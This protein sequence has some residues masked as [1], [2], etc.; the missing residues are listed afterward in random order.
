MTTFLESVVRVLRTV[1]A[2]GR[3]SNGRAVGGGWE[4][5]ATTAVAFG[6]CGNPIRGLSGAAFAHQVPVDDPRP[7][8][9][10]EANLMQKM[11]LANPTESVGYAI[12]HGLADPS[13]P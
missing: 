8:S 12:K 9:V 13:D 3:D 1:P 6:D 11:G 4:L 2:V 7:A 10:S 5:S